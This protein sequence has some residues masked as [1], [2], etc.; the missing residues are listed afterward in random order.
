VKHVVTD[1]PPAGALN[2]AVAVRGQGFKVFDFKRANSSGFN[3]KNADYAYRHQCGQPE[4]A[5][6]PQVFPL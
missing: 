6:S 2:Q 5:E 4:L 3:G 1:V